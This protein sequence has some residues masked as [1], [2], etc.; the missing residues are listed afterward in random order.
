[1]NSPTKRFRRIHVSL[2]PVEQ[3]Q[4][5]A[6]TAVVVAIATIIMVRV[7]SGDKLGLYDFGSIITFGVFGFLIVFFTLKYGQ[8]L[9]RQNQELIA[10]NAMA[11]AVNR[12]VEIDF[13][14][15]NGLLEVKRLTG[16]QLGWIY[17]VEGGKLVLKAPRGHAAA[18]HTVIPPDTPADDK[19]Y[20][21]IYS[22]TIQRSPRPILGR[23]SDDWPKGKLRAWASVPIM[24]KDTFCGVVLLASARR[25]AFDARQLQLLS[26]FAN[27]IGVAMENTALF[28]K[29]R[30]SEERYM[31]L[32]ENSPDMYHIVN[33]EGVI[34]SCNKTEANRLG[35]RKDELI[36]HTLLKLY[37]PTAHEDARQM[38]RKIFELHQELRDVEQQMITSSGERIDVSI[39][40]S[41]I[42]DQEIQPAYVRIVARDITEK[43]KM[44]AKIIHAQRIDS[45]GNLAGGI[46]HDFNNVLTSI[47]GSTAIMKRK[48]KKND[49]WF[50]YAEIIETGA[51]RGASLTRQ[52][53]TFA[54][55]GQVQFRPVLVNDIVNE[56]LS[57][58][59]RS[60]D[61]TVTI[62]QDL[63][64]RG[65]IVRGDDGQLQQAILNLLINARDAMP[66]GGTITVDSIVKDLDPQVG[67]NGS[68]RRPG[69][70]VAISVSDTGVGM[71]DAVKERIF[72]PFFTTK[73]QGKGTGLGLSVVYGVVNAHEGFI[74]VHSTPGKGSTFTLYFPLMKDSDVFLTAEN[75]TRLRKGDESILVVDDESQVG[76]VIEGM[77]RDL[78][79]DVTVASSGKAAIAQVRSKKKFDAVIL[80]MNMPSMGGK[81][82]F[83]KLKELDP[84]L[85]VIISTGYS[86]T[87]LESSDLQNSVDGFLQKPYQLEELSKTLREVFGQRR[88]LA[89]GL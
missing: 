47:L 65:S 70:Y 27:Q 31:D 24:M 26:G 50:R 17:Y 2:G 60:V 36:G 52:L 6:S 7:L 45:I 82:T 28:E 67:G 39:N 78:G 88:S 35:Y 80:D 85:R 84:D 59:E 48:M 22:P 43:K 10:L 13:L 56:T 51:K 89:A 21:W 44:E 12:S 86:N 49:P 79:Y 63:Q 71:E 18:D 1:M 16:V 42:Y 34:V 64:A 4:I 83:F 58:F 55:K 57:L 61:K 74:A 72:E 87:S 14:L 33:R 30:R 66:E 23:T 77:L 41:I 40:T 68:E 38:F 32:F 20:D 19:R 69:K 54:R 73:E 46:A 75:S 37:A 81:E 9:E 76:E 62:V 11:E 25:N 53:L 5:V 3:A 15:R 8:L 29:L